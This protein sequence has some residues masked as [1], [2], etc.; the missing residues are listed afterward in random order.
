MNIISNF[1]LNI[2]C[3]VISVRKRTPILYPTDLCERNV[4]ALL[5]A[6]RN[7]LILFDYFI[8]QVRFL[9]LFCR[10][11]QTFFFLSYHTALRSSRRC[12]QICTG[13]G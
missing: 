2:R 11:T 7:S 12:G 13:D 5:K 8:I 6:P 3:F 10:Q 9:F 1:Q 4:V